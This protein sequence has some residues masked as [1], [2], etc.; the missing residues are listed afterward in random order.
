MEKDLIFIERAYD[1][2]DSFIK[3]IKRVLE[4]IDGNFTYTWII[5]ALQCMDMNNWTI[6]NYLFMKYWEEFISKL[7]EIWQD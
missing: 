5:K 4:D 1:M 2:K 3:A 6:E 7:L